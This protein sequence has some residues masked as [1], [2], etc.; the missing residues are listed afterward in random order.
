MYN[1]WVSGY[2]RFFNILQVS[3]T[4]TSLTTKASYS[5]IWLHRYYW[6]HEKKVASIHKYYQA[7]GTAQQLLRQAPYSIYT[8]YVLKESTCD[9]YLNSVDLVLESF[10]RVGLHVSQQCYF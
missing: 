6:H 5:T 2:I 9:K 3:E 1:I 8:C 4:A 10:T 7:G